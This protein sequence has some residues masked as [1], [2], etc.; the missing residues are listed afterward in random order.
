[1][2]MIS[3]PSPV[4][5]LPPHLYQTRFLLVICKKKKKKTAVV[6]IYFLFFRLYFNRVRTHNVYF[7]FYLLYV[8]ATETE[9]G[10][11]VKFIPRMYQLLLLYAYSYTY[12]EKTIPNYFISS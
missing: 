1:M 6:F 7:T 11:R 10:L 2:V 4:H 8:L 12:T 5:T 3:S 9:S